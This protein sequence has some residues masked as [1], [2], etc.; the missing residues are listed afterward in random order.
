M[1]YIY[2]ENNHIDTFYVK[3]VI[4]DVLRI[5][6]EHYKVTTINPVDDENFRC[7]VGLKGLDYEF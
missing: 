4:G 5:K 1:Y 7:E 2:Y 3:L 6:G